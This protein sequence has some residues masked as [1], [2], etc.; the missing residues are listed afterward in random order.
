[1]EVKYTERLLRRLWYTGRELGY[2]ERERSIDA[3]SSLST[4]GGPAALAALRLL[5]EGPG[6]QI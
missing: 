1:M 2:L 4:T 6:D 3:L 5:A